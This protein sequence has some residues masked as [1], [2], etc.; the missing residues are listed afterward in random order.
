MN[1]IFL[2]ALLFVQFKV[3]IHVAGRLESQ[4][5]EIGEILYF[6]KLLLIEFQSQPS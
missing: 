6:T 2:L 4:I 3:L 1:N 5:E